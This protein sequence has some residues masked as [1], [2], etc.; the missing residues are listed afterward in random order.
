MPKERDHK[1]HN[2]KEVRS[3][4][5]LISKIAMSCVSYVFLRK[6]FY[7]LTGQRYETQT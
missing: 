6:V 5:E 4:E 2:S 3:L 7:V 1:Y